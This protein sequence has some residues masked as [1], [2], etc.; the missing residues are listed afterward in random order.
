MGAAGTPPGSWDL[1]G[2]PAPEAPCFKMFVVDEANPEGH[3]VTEHFDPAGDKLWLIEPGDEA[4]LIVLVASSAPI[5]DGDLESVL[6]EAGQ[7]NDAFVGTKE[8]SPP[9]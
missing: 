2:R 3:E 8:I 4:A 1:L 7:R 6:T 9:R 5:G